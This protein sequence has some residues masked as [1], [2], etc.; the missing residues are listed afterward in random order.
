MIMDRA[1]Q[2]ELTWSSERDKGVNTTAQRGTCIYITTSLIQGFL[3]RF[4][5]HA[6]QKARVWP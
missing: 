3:H 6:L 4:A 2:I 5:L 1:I